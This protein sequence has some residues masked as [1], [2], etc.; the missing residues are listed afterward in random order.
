VPGRLTAVQGAAAL[1]A[2]RKARSEIVQHGSL[3]AA[4]D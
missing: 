3:R 4:R 1:Q 2:F